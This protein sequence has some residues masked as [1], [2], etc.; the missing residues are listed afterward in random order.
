[1]GGIKILL[2]LIFAITSSSDS[3]IIGLNYGTKRINI[4]MTINLL[5]ALISC[6]GTIVAMMFG[7]LVLSFLDPKHACYMDKISGVLLML[8]GIYMLVQAYGNQLQ[9]KRNTKKTHSYNDMLAYPE[10]VDKD[11]SKTIDSKEAI[12]LG[13]ILS[14]NNIGLGL[15]ASMMELNV[16]IVSL[17]SLICSMLF[18]KLGCYF[19]TK[20]SFSKLAGY[21]EK[22]SAS[23]IIIF[24]LCQMFV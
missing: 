24:G 14:I 5:V 20:L 4:S 17:A 23:I 9:N 6:I 10:I 1:M 2:I 21:V 18:I 13:L 12:I 15:G 22:A 19:G 16:Y 11:N 7:G 8:L 3:F